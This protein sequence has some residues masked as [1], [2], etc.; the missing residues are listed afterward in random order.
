MA[1]AFIA[2]LVSELDGNMRSVESDICN[3]E[4]DMLAAYR[5]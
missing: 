3:G 2:E 5:S 1:V 4:Q